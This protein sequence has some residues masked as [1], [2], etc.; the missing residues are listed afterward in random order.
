MSKY[1]FYT[2]IRYVLVSVCT[3]A[4]VTVCSSQSDR[5]IDG[6][7]YNQTNPTWG[8]TFDVQP[9]LSPADYAD[10]ISLPKLGLDFDKENP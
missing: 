3:I 4:I 5:P 2:H 7:G 9:R 6:F 1:L 8:A 10:G